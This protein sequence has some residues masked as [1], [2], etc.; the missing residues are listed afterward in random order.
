MIGSAHTL[1]RLAS[2]SRSRSVVRRL[3]DPRGVREAS[4]HPRR[5]QFALHPRR[6]AAGTDAGARSGY[7]DRDHL[8]PLYRLASS[9]TRSGETLDPAIATAITSRR[10]PLAYSTRGSTGKFHAPVAT[11]HAPV[12][13]LVSSHASSKG[14]DWGNVVFV[15]AAIG[16]S[17]LLVGFGGTRTRDARRPRQAHRIGQGCVAKF[18]GAVTAGA[19]ALKGSRL[20]EP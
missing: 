12:A 17:F 4:R 10:S 1:R 6:G 20:R 15:F 19:R 13:T 11:L 5:E 3:R 7:C 8:P 2:G 18:L 9:E 16:A 14:S